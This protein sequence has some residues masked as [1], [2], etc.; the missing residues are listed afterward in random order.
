[1]CGNTRMISKCGALA[2]QNPSAFDW[3]QD[4]H[5]SAPPL[6][7]AFCRRFHS[8][9]L[10]ILTQEKLSRAAEGVTPL[11]TTCTLLS[12]F[13]SSN[14]YF[15]CKILEFLRLFFLFSSFFCRRK[16]PK[17]L[18]KALDLAVYVLCSQRKR[19]NCAESVSKYNKNAGFKIK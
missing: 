16:R 5:T 17:P 1:M 10:R 19:S 2:C 3:L 6:S 7:H 4:F 18:L 15:S 13:S 12:L 8:I 9:L 11:Y 14:L